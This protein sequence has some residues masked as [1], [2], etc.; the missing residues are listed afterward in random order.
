MNKTFKLIVSFLALI[1]CLR[2]I[3]NPIIVEYPQ[4]FI[5]ELTFSSNSAWSLE[6]EMFCKQPFLLPGSIDS[7]VLQTNEGR[8]RL[9]SF[10]SESN[11][12][13]VISCND[14]SFP[15]VIGASQDTIRV[16]TYLNQST[17]YYNFGEYL[18]HRLVFGYPESEIP[19]LSGGQSICSWEI[20]CGYPIC[21][22]KDTSPTL[23]LPNDTIGATATL[24]GDFYDFLDRRITS[25]LYQYEFSFPNNV[26]SYY[27]ELYQTSFYRSLSVFDFESSGSYS[28]KILSGNRKISSIDYLYGG[29]CPYGYQAKQVLQCESLQLNTEPGQV[30][31]QDIHL[32]DSSFRVGLRESAPALQNGLTVVCGP[33]P[34]SSSISFYLT[35]LKDMIDTQIQI[36]N[37]N[38][39][40]LKT[41]PV[42]DNALTWS[43][44]VNRDEL[45][46][47]SCYI[48]SVNV[49]GIRVKSG[50]I[51]C[52]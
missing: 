37:L 8:A 43:C 25:P 16:L 40:L 51:I 26:T 33:N 20:T 42:E 23:G 22:Y 6:L 10:P 7:I 52:Q 47:I 3:A 11:V 1:G 34:F 48:Y 18:E 36:F 44:R 21:F 9:L 14:L 24:Y 41:I 45:G 13:F 50:Q 30:V 15:L 4:V 31:V 46:S 5:S 38:G 19:T 39:Q 29:G 2:A 28:S 32:S 27:F 49:K 17:G 35:S 12:L